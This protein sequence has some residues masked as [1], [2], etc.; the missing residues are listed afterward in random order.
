MRPWD[1]ALD[2]L[3]PR[4][5]PDLDSDDA[6]LA[7]G[8]EAWWGN[9]AF[10]TRAPAQWYRATGSPPQVGAYPLGARFKANASPTTRV[11]LGRVFPWLSLRPWPTSFPDS[12]SSQCISVRVNVATRANVRVPSGEVGLVE[13]EVATF[14]CYGTLVDWE[15]GVASFL[16]DLALRSGVGWPHPGSQLRQWWEA[17]QFELIQGP[18]L[19]YK[20]VLAE[21]L[22]RFAAAYG[23]RVT[24]DDE[25]ALARSMRSWQPFADTALALRC[26]KH[27]GIRCVVVS[28]TDRDIIAHTVRQIGIDFD[29]VITAEDC[30]AYKP[31]ATVFDQALAQLGVAAERVLHVAFG[32][33][34]DI[35]PARQAGMRTA[36][37]N[38]HIEPLDDSTASPDYQWR[39]LWGL[40]R[41][42]GSP[43]PLA[44]GPV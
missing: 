15:G 6:H 18:Y 17:C 33:K 36:W 4:R 25:E 39:D 21:S 16:Y 24:A 44:A 13:I 5:C 29:A 38:R 37:I 8:A 28:N 43:P 3:V 9:R 12:L 26:V 11:R 35:S 40:A 22:R 20:E 1:T 34:Y 23:Y 2:T 41:L 42:V 19:P 27:A 10:P 7:C 32:F 31:A 30:G 14:D